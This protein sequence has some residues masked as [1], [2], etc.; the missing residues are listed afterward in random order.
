MCLDKTYRHHM[1]MCK[2]VRLRKPQHTTL[3]LLQ[4][5]RANVLPWPSKSPDLNPIKH[6][7]Y[8]VGSVFRRG[9]LATVRTVRRLTCTEICNGRM[10]RNYTAHVRCLRYVISM[11][12]RC[13]T[14]IKA[15][16]GH[17]RY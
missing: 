2:K 16:C 6:N 11:C 1:C 17:T 4:A 13:Q 9:G 10:E 12:S 7:C 14:V 8:V 5:H 3:R 15:N